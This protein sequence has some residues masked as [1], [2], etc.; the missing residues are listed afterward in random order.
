MRLLTAAVAFSISMAAQPL[1]AD[2]M[3]AVAFPARMAGPWQ[4]DTPDASRMSQ[5]GMEITILISVVN[6]MERIENMFVNVDGTLFD[7]AKGASNS[8]DGK[9]LILNSPTSANERSNADLIFDAKHNSW[10]GTF[11]RAGKTT[12]V[13][14]VRPYAPPSSSKNPLVGDWQSIS[15]LNGQADSHASGACLHVFQAWSDPFFPDGRPIVTVDRLMGSDRSY[16][17]ELSVDELGERKVSLV[18]TGG[19]GPTF[20][21]T[22][23]VDNDGRLRGS[24]G[25]GSPIPANYVRSRTAECLSTSPEI[26][27]VA[28]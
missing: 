18:L 5:F 24:W 26:E 17:K 8:W 20:F 11:V 4:T 15:A 12:S 9:R 22:G 28:H 2:R 7:L 23:S 6:G 3:A 21:Y 10:T 13:R 19:V 27:P 16:G 25:S 1:P 14:L